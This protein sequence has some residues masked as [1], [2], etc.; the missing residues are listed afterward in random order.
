MLPDSSYILSKTLKFRLTFQTV[1]DAAVGCLVWDFTTL[2]TLLFH[3]RPAQRPGGIWEL[4]TVNSRD[5]S[6]EDSPAAPTSPMQP[7]S[8]VPPGTAPDA[9]TAPVVFS[10][11]MAGGA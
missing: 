3:W 11:C 4:L 1:A 8:V 7:P 5:E 10:V 9:G 2:F 6:T